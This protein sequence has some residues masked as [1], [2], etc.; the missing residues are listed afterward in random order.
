MQT[1]GT[2]PLV[3]LLRWFDC[4]TDTSVMWTLGTVPLLSALRRFDSNRHLRNADTWL[5]LSGVCTRRFDS[6][7]DTSVMQTLDSVFLVSVLRGS[8]VIQ[9]TL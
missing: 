6:K 5:C 1:L 3:S 9:T 4:N 7:T 2:V 8:T